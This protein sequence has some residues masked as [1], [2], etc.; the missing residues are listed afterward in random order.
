M[1]V[2]V[3]EERGEAVELLRIA[4]FALV[5]GARERN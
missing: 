5:K 2:G 4:A 3:G 1:Q